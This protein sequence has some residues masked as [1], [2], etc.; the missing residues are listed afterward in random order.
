MHVYGGTRAIESAAVERAAQR[1]A[2]QDARPVDADDATAAAPKGDDA[3][4]L[5]PDATADWQ[6]QYR[7][8]RPP[9]RV[10]L[11]S[12]FVM[13]LIV[14]GAVFR[15]CARTYPFVPASTC[16]PC[17]CRNGVLKSCRRVEDG[18]RALNIAGG[19]RL[20]ISHAA[21]EPITYIR[22]RAFDG[23]KALVI[24][25]WFNGDESWQESTF[26]DMA[27]F[28][29]FTNLHELILLNHGATCCDFTRLPFLVKCCDIDDYDELK[30]RTFAPFKYGE[31]AKVKYCG[32]DTANPTAGSDATDPNHPTAKPSLAPLS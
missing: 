24:K 14:F 16:A 3:L 7:Y 2:A 8:A 29:N 25:F 31:C 9:R 17:K 6:P 30:E 13:I 10:S 27:A 12:A 26:T 19:L 5:G 23:L 21:S 20:A 1:A 32:Q 18:A 15:L 28:Q 11:G 22:A 4:P